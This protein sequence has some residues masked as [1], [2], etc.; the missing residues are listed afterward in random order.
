MI[1]PPRWYGWKP[2]QRDDRDRVYVPK[3]A[4]IPTRASGFLSTTFLPPVW[5]QGATGFCTGY[6]LAGVGYFL[7]A[8]KG[9]KQFIPSARFPYWN[10]RVIEGTTADDN[11]A[12]IRNAVKGV[13]KKGL[14]SETFCPTRLDNFSWAP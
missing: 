11:G 13:V 5:D 10:A 2:D 6:A 1:A 7:R 9:E 8:F 3:M 12:Q 14:C 4:R